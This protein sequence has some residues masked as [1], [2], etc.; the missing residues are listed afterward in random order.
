MAYPYERRDWNRDQY[1]WGWDNQ[2]R[3]GYGWGRED[4]H[5][6]YCS[7]CRRRIYRDECRTPC[8]RYRRY[9]NGIQGKKYIP[10]RSCCHR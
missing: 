2:D 9:R 8:V 4:G 6:G 5:D 7:P 1:D 3:N 10:S